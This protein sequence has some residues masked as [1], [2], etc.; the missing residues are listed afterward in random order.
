M[1]SHRE[2]AIAAARKLL[3]SFASSPD[4]RRQARAIQ[5]TLAGAG[6]WSSAEREAIDDL[7]AWLAEM[8]AEASL[9]PRCES[10]LHGLA[11]R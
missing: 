1:S 3:R 9:R 4:P 11:S 5:S 2:E 8:P 10:V 6:G 7:G